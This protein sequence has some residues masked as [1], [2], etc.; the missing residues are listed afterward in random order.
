MKFIK[1]V[2]TPITLAVSKALPAVYEPPK[3]EEKPAVTP[4]PAREL[5]PRRPMRFVIRRWK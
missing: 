2:A 5:A 4:E 1:T 3:V